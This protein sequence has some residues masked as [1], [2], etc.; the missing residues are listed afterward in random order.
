M[1]LLKWSNLKQYYNLV[2]LLSNNNM[3]GYYTIGTCKEQQLR[4]YVEGVC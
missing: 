3:I 1:L 2:L 4:Q